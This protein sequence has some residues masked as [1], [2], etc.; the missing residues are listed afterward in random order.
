L[1]A[2]SVWDGDPRTRLDSLPGVLAHLS[3]AWERRDQAN[4][5]LVRYDD[6]VRNLDASMRDLAQRLGV[7]VDEA[8]WPDLVHAATFE[9]MRQDARLL[10][11]DALG[12]LKDPVQFFR[13][14]RSGDGRDVLSAAQLAAYEERLRGSLDPALL[15]WLR[16]G[17]R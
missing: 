11:P 14:G 17:D 6:L 16:R 8:R 13:A 3:D 7:T 9:A 12:V 5:V 15:A 4:V 2:W 10:A 1:A